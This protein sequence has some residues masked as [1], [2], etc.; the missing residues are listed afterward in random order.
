[1]TA[2]GAAPTAALDCREQTFET[3]VAGLPVAKLSLPADAGPD[4]TRA[5]I[6]L[7][8]SWR[9]DGIW[10][11]SCRVPAD[12]MDLAPM[13]EGVGFQAVETLITFYQPARPARN[14]TAETGLARADEIDACV[15]LALSAFTY[16]RLHRD[17]RV[18]HAVADAI[19]AAWVR[20]DMGGRAAAPLVARIDGRVAGFNLC[21]HAGRTAIIDLIAVAAD[22]RRR[23][24]AGQMIEAAFAHFGDTIDGIRVG[25]QEDNAASVKLY[26]SAGFAV[27]SRQVTLHWVN[28]QVTP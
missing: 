3:G 27:E 19:R 22:F 4:I 12:R 9:T 26:E 2:A 23:G 16:D 8:T 24:L 5:L 7:E 10:L 14:L 1:M 11:V 15:D 21:L 28:P 13:L 6:D 18:P 17:A 20:N 25:T